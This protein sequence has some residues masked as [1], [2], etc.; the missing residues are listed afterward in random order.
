MQD[1]TVTLDNNEDNKHVVSGCSFLKICCYR[2]RLALIVAF[3]ILD[4]LQGS[5]A[6]HLRCGGIFLLIPTV[7]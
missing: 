6:T 4:I 7:K 5:A 1:V 3:K 2:S